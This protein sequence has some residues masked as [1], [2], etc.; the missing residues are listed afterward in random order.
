MQSTTRDAGA[1]C[2]LLESQAAILRRKVRP[3]SRT[4]RPSCTF[5]VVMHV[6]SHLYDCCAARSDPAAETLRHAPRISHRMAHAHPL[7]PS[8]SV[9]RSL[10]M[11]GILWCIAILRVLRRSSCLR[12]SALTCGKRMRHSSTA[13]LLRPRLRLR[14]A[15]VLR[16]G[17]G[18]ERHQCL[19]RTAQARCD[20][21]P[22]GHVGERGCA[23][24]VQSDPEA[25]RCAA[26][27]MRL[28]SSRSAEAAQAAG[29]PCAESAGLT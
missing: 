20:G 1:H 10:K 26:L 3:L 25:V 6:A 5:C 15:T 16:S 21:S 27:A 12:V 13:S 4:N 7:V 24:A 28:A 19:C 18:R 9:L 23:E 2:D 29:R 8:C 22:K 14:C 17:C 11:R